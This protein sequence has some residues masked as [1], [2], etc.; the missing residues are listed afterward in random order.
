MSAIERLLKPLDY[1]RVQHPAKLKYDFFIPASLTVVVAAL[2]YFVPK[3]P[4]IFGNSGL[5]SLI[6]SLLQVLTGFFIASLAAVAT[7]NKEGMDATMPGDPPKLRIIERGRIK[8][9]DLSRRRFLSL[10]FGYLAFVSLGLYMFGGAA[11]LFA[12]GAK[13]AIP[14]EWHK[15]VHWVFLLVYG[16]VL[17]NLMITT[18]LGLFYMSDRIHRHDPM[19]HTDPQ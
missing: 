13:T 11:N 8:I 5:I 16:F 3:S 6:N 12:E 18:L 17:S 10:M 9:I 15:A 14:A 19:L 1:L 4:P 7:F 2:F